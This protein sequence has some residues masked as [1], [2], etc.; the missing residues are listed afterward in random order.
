MSGSPKIAFLALM[1]GSLAGCA[2]P[3]GTRRVDLGSVREMLSRN[4]ISDNQPS[5]AS[6]Q[7]LLRLDLDE[8]YQN[9]PESALAELHTLAVQDMNGDRLFALAEYSYLH[10]ASLDR[11]CKRKPRRQKSRRPTPRRHQI[12]RPECEAARHYFIAASIYAFAFA[13]PEETRPD[14][15]GLDPRL[16]TAV[17][18]YNLAV[19][20]AIK[21]VDGAIVPRDISIPFH[22]G[23]LEL[24]MDPEGFRY[25]DRRLGDLVPAAQLEV[26]GLRNRYRHA[27]I[28]APF[29]ASTIEEDGVALP[30][31]SARVVTNLRVPITILVRYQNLNHGLRTGELRGR[32]EI[33]NELAALSVEIDGR[34]VPLEYETT[35]A[36]AYSLQS[37]KLWDF[38]LSGFLRGDALPVP[39]GL[40]M[41]EPYRRGKIPIVLVHGT[42]SSPA[43]WAEMLNEFTSDPIL[44]ARYQFWIFIYATG[45]PIL[46][47][48]SLL[49]ESL[50]ATLAEIDPEETDPALR[51]MVVVGHSQG[52]LL[53]KLQVVSSGTYFW[54]TLSDKSFD[55]IEIRSETRELMSKAMFFERQPFVERV[56]FIS[57]PHRGSFLA[58][59]WLGRFAS[60]L[61]TAPKVLLGTSLDLAGAG[62]A[63]VGAAARR[64]VGAF[65]FFNSEEDE[66]NRSIG[67]LPSSVDNMDPDHSFILTLQSIPVDSG[68][69]A[70]S[71]IPVRGAAPPDGQ[72]DGVVEYS[73]AHI[74]EAKSEYIVFHSSHSTQSHPKTIQETRRILL[75]HLAAP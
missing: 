35:S 70:H 42:A 44:R 73:S 10:A 51:R 50:Q 26:R 4:A 11:N 20:S 38:E 58:G 32:V 22:L 18:L 52:G 12:P 25:A 48:A 21:P 60:S 68:V 8:T 2:S 1:L 37:S 28:G 29:V 9:D 67:S 72:N 74:A 65:G 46:Y 33:Y 16:R 53:T 49:R 27:G 62:V 71:I 40:M 41:M 59:D 56:I 75:E 14:P 47:S 66:L 64:G 55:E 19:T 61:F 3:V 63:L 17:D 6:N 13:F 23:T 15:S 45:N 7:V 5:I 24:K 69:T 54:D 57:T 36:L 30:L 43:R 39:D 34:S 31:T